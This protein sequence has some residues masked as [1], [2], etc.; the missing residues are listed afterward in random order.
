MADTMEAQRDHNKPKLTAQGSPT[1]TPS[2]AGA[3]DSCSHRCPLALTKCC[4]GN[5]WSITAFEQLVQRDSVMPQMQNKPT[6]A[7]GTLQV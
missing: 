2:L 1:A 7:P 6:T 3:G 4:L 5:F